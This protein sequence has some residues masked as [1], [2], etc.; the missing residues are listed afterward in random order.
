MDKST[1]KI[2]AIS[3][4]IPTLNGGDT[5]AELLAMLSIQ[6]VAI[7]EI[8]VVDSASADDTLKIA[9]EYGVEIVRI[10]PATF[11]HGGTRSFIAKRAKGEILVFFTQDAVPK[12]RDSIEKLIKPLLEDETVATS[13]GRQL[14]DF[15]ANH[16]AI[17]LRN[18]N[19]PDKGA[20][21][22]LKD[23]QRAGLRTIFTSNSFAC[24]RKSSLES[25]GYFQDGLIFGE[26]TVAVGRLLLQGEKIVYVAE[27]AVYHSHN[28]RPTEEF[29]RYFDI[30]V[31]HASEKWLLD[32]FGRAEGQGLKYIKY[33]SKVLLQKKCFDLIPELCIR[34][35]LKYFGY[36]LG[37]HHR[38]LPKSVIKWFSMHNSWWTG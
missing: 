30:G 22:D 9:E 17:N 1:N 13:Y 20:V 8:L 33:E 27:A 23:K 11:D 29:K 16:F 38:V 14:P 26:D 35:L 15:N 6:T 21:R 10:D 4:L 18:F 24:Y 31:L 32:T 19:Y 2:P 28:Y 5:L 3:I 37:F 25:I 36:K 7:S 34:I 12:K